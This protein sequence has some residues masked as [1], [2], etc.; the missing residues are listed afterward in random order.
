[1]NKFF[2]GLQGSPNTLR[3]AST[4][5][6]SSHKKDL[7][8]MKEEWVGGHSDTWVLPSLHKVLGFQPRLPHH[9]GH[10]M[11]TVFG[12]G[13]GIVQAWCGSTSSNIMLINNI[14]RPACRVSMKRPA[15]KGTSPH[16]RATLRRAAKG[17][18]PK[19]E[20]SV[21]PSDAFYAA[22]REKW[23]SWLGKNFKSQ[24]YA[25]WPGLSGEWNCFWY[26]MIWG[27]VPQNGWFI[28]EH[29]IKMDNLGVSL[30]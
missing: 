29:P 11:S 6:L 1:M 22:S 13:Q 7:A 8:L 19:S 18:A 14:K 5:A 30:F 2:G 26:G 12:I 28:V 25:A 27:W 4:C 16:P 24:S 21:V 20:L 9:R 15:A 10:Q 23:R 17:G 3:M